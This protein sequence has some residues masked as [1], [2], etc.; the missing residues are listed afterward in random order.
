MK[1][2]CSRLANI[3][4]GYKLYFPLLLSVRSQRALFRIL[5][6]VFPQTTVPAATLWTTLL[7]V[8]PLDVSQETKPVICLKSLLWAFLLVISRHAGITG[9][10]NQYKIFHVGTLSCILRSSS[11]PSFYLWHET[12]P[13]TMHR[14]SLYPHTLPWCRFLADAEDCIKDTKSSFKLWRCFSD[15]E[16]NK[17]IVTRRD[18]SFLI[19]GQ[20]CGFMLWNTQIAMK[21]MDA[22]IVT[23][24]QLISWSRKVAR[25][26]IEI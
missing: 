17:A 12:G 9:W 20:V 13:T 23:V 1:L 16:S 5:A 2:K 21:M 19:D 10:H 11:M 6:Q 4:Q 22:S 14:I 15:P 3:F 7:I 24:N 26:S 8:A 25:S 18:E